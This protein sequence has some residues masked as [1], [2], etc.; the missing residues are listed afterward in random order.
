MRQ[1][2]EGLDRVLPRGESLR[3]QGDAQHGIV[4][5][6]GDDARDLFLDPQL[7]GNRHEVLRQV[8][9]CVALGHL[10]ERDCQTSH[11]LVSGDEMGGNHNVG[12]STRRPTFYSFCS[13]CSY[14]EQ[15]S[16]P[17]RPRSQSGSS[18]AKRFNQSSCCPGCQQIPPGGKLSRCPSSCRGN[19]GRGTRTCHFPKDLR[20]CHILGSRYLDFAS[21]W[22]MHTP[23]FPR[24]SSRSRTSLFFEAVALPIASR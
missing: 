18:R 6:I 10:L 22:S 8:F 21:K 9:T 17:L 13:R 14:R 20:S 12:V 16:A 23:S 11:S 15:G 2:P 5:I 19:R 1:A 7:L 4:G 24:T 3:C